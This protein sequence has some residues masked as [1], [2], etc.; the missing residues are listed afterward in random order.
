MKPAKPFDSSKVRVFNFLGLCLFSVLGLLNPWNLEKTFA[1]ANFYQGKTISAVVGTKAGDVYDL[2][3]RL[4]AEFLP[5]F[6]PGNPNIIIQNVAG[7]ASLV[8]ANQVYNIAKPDGLTLGAI[9]PALYLDQL[10]KRPEVKYDWNKFAWI[11]S[12]VRSNHMMYMRADTPYKTIDDVHAATHP[13]KRSG[14][15][16]RSIRLPP[17]RLSNA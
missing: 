14:A 3:P 7:A 12:P 11:G 6:I 2:Y 17:P 5:K 13:P 9:Y 1:Q 16:S 8:A 10:V 15:S 4:L